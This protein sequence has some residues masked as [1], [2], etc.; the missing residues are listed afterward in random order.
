MMYDTIRVISYPLSQ[1][2]KAYY[3]HLCNPEKSRYRINIG[4]IHGMDFELRGWKIIFSLSLP[5]V[6]R[7][8]SDGYGHNWDALPL[9]TMHN[10]IEELCMDHPPLERGSLSRVDIAGIMFLTN[11]TQFYLRHLDTHPT[12]ATR[13]DYSTRRESDSATVGSRQYV[14]EDRTLS[15]YDK[16]VEAIAH[17]QVGIEAYET[18]DWQVLKYELQIKKHVRKYLRLEGGRSLTIRN[19]QDPRLLRQAANL[20]MKEYNAIHKISRGIDTPVLSSIKDIESFGLARLVDEEG[21]AAIDPFLNEMRAKGTSERT[22]SRFR[23]KAK[24]AHKKHYEDKTTDTLKELDDVMHSVHQNYLQA[25]DD[26]EREYIEMHGPYPAD[27]GLPNNETLQERL[28]RVQ[29]N[30]QEVDPEERRRLREKIEGSYTE[31]E[32]PSGMPAMQG[33]SVPSIPPMLED[34][35]EIASGET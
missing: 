10:A 20:W 16:M 30:K 23:T 6:A 26:Y 22:L 1:E 14:G 31:E 33:R 13:V 32:W 9:M 4:H 5:K 27:N 35:S 3:E 8:K 29:E 2:E 15:F 34:S 19:L 21:L 25:I 7:L 17:G 24:K 18:D 12:L 11:P 28:E